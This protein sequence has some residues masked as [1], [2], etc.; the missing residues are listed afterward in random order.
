MIEKDISNLS[1]NEII[2]KYNNMK[3]FIIKTGLADSMSD[4]HIRSHYKIDVERQPITFYVE[5]DVKIKALNCKVY[6]NEYNQIL[7]IETEDFV[8]IS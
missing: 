4:E 2:Q 6:R 3:N 5:A 1:K 7:M 8:I